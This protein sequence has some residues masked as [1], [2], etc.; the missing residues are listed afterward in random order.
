MSK[1]H[2]LFIASLSACNF[3]FA[4]KDTT[5]KQLVNLKETSKSL[6]K[7]DKI[8]LGELFLYDSVQ[9]ARHPKKAN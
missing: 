7:T 4:Q 6:D 9:N 3:L 8:R 5:I 1:K 2:F